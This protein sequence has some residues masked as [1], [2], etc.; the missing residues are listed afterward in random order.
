MNK[1]KK[2]LLDS[3]DHDVSILK[4]Q[5]EEERRIK[6]VRMSKLIER[7]DHCEVLEVEIISLKGDIEKSNNHLMKYETKN[8]KEIFKNRDQDILKNQLEESKKI[9]D[10]FV[11]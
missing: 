10:A 11:N 2:E 1:E 6:E 7:E 9:E 8:G 4:P 3:R 5:L